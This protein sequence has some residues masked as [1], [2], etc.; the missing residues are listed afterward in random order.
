MKKISKQIKGVALLWALV[1]ILV[2]LV[3]AGSLSGLV[4]KEL[5]MSLNIDQSEQAYAAARSGI[6]VGKKN[7]PNTPNALGTGTG[8][9]SFSS[10]VQYTVESVSTDGSNPPNC[11]VEARGDVSGANPVTRKLTAT[12][13]RAFI[14]SQI[15]IFPQNST[16]PVLSTSPSPAIS[17]FQDEGLVPPIN[18]AG[19]S[20]TSF[21]QQ[22]DLILPTSGSAYVGTAYVAGGVYSK[23]LLVGVTVGS[24]GSRTV[25]AKKFENSSWGTLFPLGTLDRSDPVRI[26]INYNSGF[27]KIEAKQKN[28]SG[29][30]TCVASTIINYTG[31][32]ANNFATLS[33]TGSK[34]DENSGDDSGI[35]IQTTGA[36]LE[37][38]VFAY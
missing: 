4:I 27:F 11:T 23:A 25:E 17:Y 10:S 32:T 1:V 22:F 36:I 38:I 8:T 18:I 21:F 12:F 19:Y 24:G 15:M 37:N 7:C 33:S 26:K 20:G 28:S 35:T 31:Y 16:A 3:I 14:E 6:E 13:N 30:D 5:R 34:A 29:P 9:A 2:L